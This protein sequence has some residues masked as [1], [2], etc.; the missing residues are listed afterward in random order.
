[1]IIRSF[2]FCQR[3]TFFAAHEWK[4]LCGSFALLIII[5]SLAS[6][7]SAKYE[8]AGEDTPRAVPLNLRA[9]AHS[10]EAQINTVIIFGGPGS[11]KREAYWDEYLLS[12]TN[13]GG[14]PVDLTSAT[15]IDFQGNPVMS[16]DNPWEL[17]EQ[18]KAWVE[19]YSSGTGGVIIKVGATSLITG[20]V[21]GGTGAIALTAAAGM[22]SAAPIMFPCIAIGAVVMLPIVAIGTVTHNVNHKHSIEG[23]FKRRRLVLPAV[24]QPGQMTQGSLFFRI[25]PGPKQLT[26]GFKGVEPG[27]DV[28]VDL[29][30][31]SDLHI[32]KASKPTQ[33]K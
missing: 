27:F 13:H 7:V 29:A 31:L 23:E 14:H 21:V 25:T 5:S 16:G 20:A 11:W 12:I 15:L 18:S 1:M 33:A 22:G 32:D 6:C 19:N 2:L 10:V 28:S 30:P 24:I 17:Q 3:R 9:E 26:L 4:N 8:M